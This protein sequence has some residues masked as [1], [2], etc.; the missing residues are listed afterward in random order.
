M[1]LQIRYTDNP[2]WHEILGVDLSGEIDDAP[3]AEIERTYDRYGVVVFRGQ[4]LA[5]EQQVRFS[6]RF[7]PLD[8]FVLD[9]FNLPSLPKI[10]VVSNIAEDGRPIGMADAGRY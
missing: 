1:E 7:G 10:F 6:R 9:R 4:K 8:R 3:F 5:P 2:L